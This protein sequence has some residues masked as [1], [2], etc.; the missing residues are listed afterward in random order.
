MNDWD[1]N[2]VT[3]DNENKYFELKRNIEFLMGLLAQDKVISERIK[4]EQYLSTAWK[5]V[6][7]ML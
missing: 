5:L 3:K 2:A 4:S 1:E 6:K 7:K